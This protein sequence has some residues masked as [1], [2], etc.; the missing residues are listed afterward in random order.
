MHLRIVG[1][2]LHIATFFHASSV[3]RRPTTKRESYIYLESIFFV[4]VPCQDSERNVDDNEG[5]DCCPHCDTV[6]YFLWQVVEHFREVDRI[7]G[8]NKSSPEASQ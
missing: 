6:D 8:S 5:N 7:D 1:D 2:S 4:E 3:R